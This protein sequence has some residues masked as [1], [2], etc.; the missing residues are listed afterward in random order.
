MIES[1]SIKNE[2]SF[3]DNP[4]LF[5]QLSQVNFLFG[6]NG[7][8]KTTISRIIADSSKFPRCNVTWKDGNKLETIVY[9][10]DFVEKNF[11][12][13]TELK[14]IFTLGEKDTSIIEQIRTAKSERDNLLASIGQLYKTLQ[15]DDG[16][17]GKKGEL[18]ELEDL[19]SEQCWEKKRKFD[20]NF[21]E[22]FRS[23]QGSKAKFKYKILSEYKTNK[24]DSKELNE[25]EEKAKAI[26]VNNNEL[27][28]IIN[29]PD[30]TDILKHESNPILKKNI[31]G[32][33]DVDIAAL[34]DKLGNSDWV[35]EGRQFYENTEHI[36]P[37]C[38]QPVHESFTKS[39]NDYFDRSYQKDIDEISNLKNAYS[40]D[41][42]QLQA[43]LNDI[44]ISDSKF[45][46]IQKL[47]NQ[48]EILESSIRLNIQR[49][50]KKYSEPS[51]IIELESLNNTIL[52][53]KNIIEIANNGILRNNKIVSNII[54]EKQQ[55]IS[56]IWKY[57]IESE[58][59]SSLAN[60]FSKKENIEKSIK[61]IT[62]KISECELDKKNVD[63][64]IKSLE[65][66]ITSIQ[67]TITT[68]NDLLYSFGFSGFKL[69]KSSREGFY[70]IVRDDGSDASNTLSEGE[71]NFITFLYFYHLLK[72]SEN[73]SGVM[74]DR[75]IVIDDPV[76]SLDNNILFIVNSLIRELFSE[77]DKNS[78]IKQ[79]FVF[80]HNVY[81]HK[82]LT[83]NPRGKIKSLN[84]ST[85]WII[86]KSE[87]H[88]T[89]KRYDLNPIKSSYE[90]LWLEV[91]NPDRSIIS[92]Q[93]NLRRILDNYFTILGHINPDDI[94]SKFEGK[95]RMICKSLFSWVNDGSHSAYDDLYVTLDDNM[96]DSYLEVFRLIFI[97]TNQEE[98]Y[99]MMMGID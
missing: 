99:K 76:C 7:T 21:K 75:V 20:T 40:S 81:F 32:K 23:V 29:L 93:N 24:A 9:N 38:Q 2:A 91:K 47:K 3:G 35:K 16:I 5:N 48:K 61:T 94:Y 34:I 54:I 65:K 56:E 15:G 36:C 70:K 30:S 77:M 55:L 4:Q 44:I 45:I 26:F 86:K 49:I 84:K 85:Y 89:I 59:K 90:L 98:H 60:Y 37:F 82:E 25:L 8:G 96:V 80:T 12:Q 72:G 78:S 41:C 71:K 11:S 63:V 95:D 58:L 46:D 6:S 33:S 66:N 62:L 97:K 88:S 10:R 13:T 79:I 92:I 51:R 42:K 1:I 74:T 31:I 19:F 57:L 73:E 53:I 39:L 67:P 83:F 87:S 17:S 50:D 27:F 64:K 69:S 18:A 14:G 68:I 22:A 43:N 28:S 52:N